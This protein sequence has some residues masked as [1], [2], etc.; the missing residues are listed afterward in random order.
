MKR[1]REFKKM[2]IDLRPLGFDQ[3]DSEFSYF[4]TPKNANIIGWADVDGIHYCT[5]PQ[6]G[7]MI[8]AVSPMN[9]GDY[10]HPIARNFEDLL[11]LLLS[12]VDM[13]ALEQCHAWNEEQFRAF[14]LDYP[15]TAEQQAVLDSIKNKLGLEPIK[16]VFA[17][18]KELQS[19]FNLSEIPYTEDY[20]DPEMNPDS[21]DCPEEWSVRFD[22]GFWEKGSGRIGKEIA[23]HSRFSWGDEQWHIP[24]VY[25]CGKGM[26]IDFCIEIDPER[27]KAFI[28]K[29]DLTRLEEE[30]VTQELQDL[31]DQ[32]NPL[33]IEFQPTVTVNGKQLIN[34]NGT[35]ISWIP[36][37]LL[38]D[39]VQNDRT[40][41][42]I[43]A[44][45]GLDPTKAWVFHRL[46]CLW[47]ASKKP[48][49]KSV[50]LQQERA[51]AQ[52]EGIHF[53]N[54]AIGEEIVFT[55]PIRG[56]EHK[57]TI[58]KYEQQELSSKTFAH[59]EYEFPTHHTA[60]TFTLEPDLPVEKFRV[61][62]C[63]SNDPPKR[64]IQNAF[65][66]QASYDAAIAVI[67]GKDNT[68]FSS[69][70]EI[71]A[72]HFEPHPDVEWKMIFHEKIME[73]IKVE[74]M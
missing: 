1:F 47:A 31:I 28:E 32:E 71:S 43:I 7:E 27:E 65:A 35:A 60:M 8:F 69:H 19:G 20:Y 52:I 2:N 67:G 6:F 3:H 42:H 12:C 44:H 62:D 51:P 50:I 64:H 23:V 57:L 18:V 11:R 39:D 49:V 56:S 26:V 70:M 73:D 72:L 61:R 37:N 74:L 13:A 25:I 34:K 58:L 68:A 16:N 14:L 33:N 66:P 63:L 9:T 21:P 38:P 15:A 36:A 5:I 29:W 41:G 24:S 46:S 22:S 45:Y 48:E 59:E 40:A 17:Y 30:S 4:C 54:P 53:C 55:H 10:V